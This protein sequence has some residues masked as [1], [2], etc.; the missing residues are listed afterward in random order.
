[1]PTKPDRIPPGIRPEDIITRPGERPMRFTDEQRRYVLTM[2][3][4][5]ITQADMA[6][7]LDIDLKTLRKHFRRELD[8]GPTEANVRVAQ[9]LYTNATKH[10]HAG[11]QIWWTKSRMGW[12][13]NV[14]ADQLGPQ[15]VQFLHLVAMRAFSD[16]LNAQRVV[17]GNVVADATSDNTNVSTPR[18]LMEPATE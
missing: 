7:V 12:K 15:S 17:D 1:M 13:D 8:T 6:K 2:S 5:G 16:E 11:A 14:T 3:G 18:N 4:F 9:A 10:M